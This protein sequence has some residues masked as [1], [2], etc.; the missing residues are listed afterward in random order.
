[1]KLPRK[2]RE[3]WLLLAFMAVVSAPAAAKVDS[4]RVEKSERKLY[5]HSGE[6]IVRA[7]DISLGGT[8]VGHKTTEGDQKTPG[9]FSLILVI[10]PDD[11]ELFVL[12][13]LHQH[14]MLSPARHTP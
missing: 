8:P 12:G 4:V 14:R 10:D 2:Y 7:Y 1:M 11:V 13:Q 5:L 9:V 6:D 3:S